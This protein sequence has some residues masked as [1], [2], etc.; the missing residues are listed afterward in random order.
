MRS[1]TGYG[2]KTGKIPENVLK[3][4]VLKQIKT[5]REEV[6]NGAGIGEDCAV[7]SFGG[8]ELTAVSADSASYAIPEAPG[9]AV[10]AAVNRLAASGAEPAAILVYALLPV[11]TEEAYI[12]R[13]TERIEEQ[14]AALHIQAA[15]VDTEITDSVNRP[16][17]T[18][19]GIGR[20][21]RER[22]FRENKAKPGQDIVISK[23]IGLEGTSLLA[24]AKEKE[25]LTRYP[26]RMVR[27][28][29]A[30]DRYL[31]VLP[32]AAVAIS[33]GVCAMHNVTQGGIFG[34]LWELAKK[35]GVGLEADLKKIPVRQETVEVCEFFAINPYELVSGGCLLMTADNGHALVR[36]LEA[37]QIPA[38]AVGRITEGNDRVVINGGE[39]RFLE[40][41]GNDEI[42]KALQ[43]VAE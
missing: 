26:A 17:L 34:A 13:M 32:E 21:K 14:C 23:W 20:I 11:E 29:G 4:S 33:S 6:L 40:P 3:R 10:H 39:K 31:S 7:L 41:P 1:R 22:D 5:K 25:L 19:T 15:G 38:A 27:E 35:A 37:R 16:V 9:Y 28:A 36:E 43:L 8:E 12:R 30:F 2:M 24:R 18:V 42:Y